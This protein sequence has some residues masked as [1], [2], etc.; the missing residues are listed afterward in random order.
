ML[1]KV[2]EDLIKKGEQQGFLTQDEILEV[3]PDAERRLDELDS[4]Y[5]ILLAGGIDVF[6]SVTPE[7]PEIGRAHV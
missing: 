6:E 7:E 3:F 5:E 2:T 4:L 1:R